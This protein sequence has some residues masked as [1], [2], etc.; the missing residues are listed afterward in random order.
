MVSDVQGGVTLVVSHL[1]E[2]EPDKYAETCEEE[3]DP[4]D[5]ASN[6]ILSDDD[7]AAVTAK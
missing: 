3:L 4:D 5:L 1:E 2:T 7:S 6:G